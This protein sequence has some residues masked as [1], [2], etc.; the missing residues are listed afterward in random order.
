[1]AERHKSMGIVSRL[2]SISISAVENNT[3]EHLLEC[4]RSGSISNEGRKMCIDTI[5]RTLKG[6]LCTRLP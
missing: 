1:M 6:V 4:S 5:H 2:D 3:G